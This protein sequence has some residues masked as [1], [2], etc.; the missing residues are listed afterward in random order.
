MTRSK[1]TYTDLS[2]AILGHTNLTYAKRDIRNDV[3]HEP[4]L[5]EPD[6]RESDEREPEPGEIERRDV[7]LRE[8]DRRESLRRR[9]DRCP[10]VRGE[11]GRRVHAQRAIRRTRT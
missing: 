2:R 8:S 11:P 1:I 10:R 6:S 4:D 9:P 3:P 5:G 7:E